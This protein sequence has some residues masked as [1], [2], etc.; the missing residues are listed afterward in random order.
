MIPHY[1]LTRSIY[2]PAICD[3]DMVARRL[4]IFR[5][6]TVPSMAAQ[7]V[8]PTWWVLGVHPNDPYLSARIA[9]AEEVDIDIMI[10][11]M[12]SGE[13]PRLSARLPYSHDWSLP[14]TLKLTTRMDDDDALLPTFCERLYERVPATTEVPQAFM[15]PQGY[16][17]CG[18][19]WEPYRHPRNMFVSVL[20][21]DGDERN[22][23][24]WWHTKLPDEMPTVDVDDE[25]A[26]VFFRHP[27]TISN[28]DPVTRP[29]AELADRLPFTVP[30]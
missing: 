8:M 3:L 18:D 28:H 10:V 1:V 23:Y 11:P 25:P 21:P 16:R 7:T 9:L 27:D 4:E 24:N 26:W 17:I 20:T 13:T 15:F 22:V 19:R 6:V 5:T 14:D 12:P 29:L 2:D 30:A